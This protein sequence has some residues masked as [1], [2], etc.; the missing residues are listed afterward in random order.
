M[1]EHNTEIV[2]VCEPSE[3]AYQLTLDV[4]EDL[5][6]NP[7]PNQPDL[8]ILLDEFAG[9]LDAAFI[10]SPHAY[11]HDQTKQ[12][13]QA[14]L[15][16]LL[17]KPMVLT[18][19]EAESLIKTRDHTGKV[20]VVAFQ[21]GLSPHI[22]LASQLIASGQ[23]GELL[24]ISGTVWQNW[25]E[26]HP[27]TWHMIPEISGGGFLFTTGAHMLNTI[28]ELAGQDFVD[29]AA[30]LD[31][32]DKPVDITGVVMG[33]LTSGALVTINACGATVKSCTSEIMVFGTQ[34]IIRTGQWGE[35]LLI[36]RHDE[37]ELHEVAVPPSNGTWGQFLQ[38]RNGDIENPTPPEIGLRMAKFWQAIQSS[39]AQ[40]G[41]PVPYD[42]HQ[43]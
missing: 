31:N 16:V 2:A 30:W 4:F 18:V 10:I 6:I 42:G 27:D 26:L 19:A 15:D 23:L 22:Q 37:T 14:G 36:Q 3:K 38:I 34:G 20:L 33:R 5:G 41:I 29:V 12:C 11:H 35:R 1:L 40:N 21:G 24:T 13:L 39:A 7:P 25:A 9:Q 32:R 17:E 8:A 43:A 28:Q